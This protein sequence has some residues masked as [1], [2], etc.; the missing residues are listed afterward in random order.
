MS[1][2]QV[3]STTTQKD[4]LLCTLNSTYQ[5][6]S[7]GLR[8]I[9][10]QM[11]ELTTQTEMIEWTI[12]ENPRNIV[13]KILSYRPKIVG[14]GVYIWNN[15]E[16]FEVC[17]IL[18]KVAPDIE[19]VL[20]GPE[21]SFETEG[22]RLYQLADHIICGEADLLFPQFCREHLSGN[23]T[24][25]K[26]VRGALPPLPELKLPYYLYS[27]NDIANRVIYVEASRGCP[28]KCEYCLSSLDKSVRSFNL[29]QFLSDL[30]MLINR[31]A[32]CFK[33]VD[34][35]FNLSPT[36]STKILN[37]FKQHLDKGLFLHFE[38]VPDRLPIEIRDLIKDFPAGSL[39]FEVGIQTLNPQ[40]AMNVS[41]KNDLVKVAENFDFINTNTH[42]HTHADLIV[43]LP[44]ETLESFGEGFDRLAAMGPH[45]IQVGILK[46]LKGTPI[47][48]HESGFQMRYQDFSPFQI[49]STSTMDYSTLQLMNRFA[50][51]WDLYANSGDFPQFMQWMRTFEGSFFWNFMK[52]V[53]Y[54]SE[55]YSETHSI[56][57]MNLAEKAYDY[58]VRRSDDSDKAFDIIKADFCDGA[59]KRDIPP[60][61]KS[62]AIAKGLYEKSAVASIAKKSSS[63]NSRQI[64]HLS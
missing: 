44:G 39:Q 12:K 60:F 63:L 8:Y 5:H 1:H 57:L 18:K 41:R 25:L 55:K 50:K 17:S 31:G 61:M 30:E 48:R 10:A 59:K 35:T 53:D 11:A 38:M 28:Y 42:V 56:S 40:V 19:L 7:F 36:T 54:L 21:I 23:E 51:F 45:E 58:I 32:R 3:S 43:G 6:S 26:I 47:I 34:R 14:F 62:Q 22:Q 4:I 15:E 33:F 37:F 2:P 46:R 24:Q 20:G 29:D 9:L 64:Q 52:F 27:D 13:E 16:V 49:L